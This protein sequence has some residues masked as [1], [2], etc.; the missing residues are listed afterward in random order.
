MTLPRVVTEVPTSGLAVPLPWISAMV[1][2]AGGVTGPGSTGGSTGAAAPLA[3]LGV[4]EA[5]SVKS[6]ELLLL[7]APLLR[8]RLLTSLLLVGAVAAWVSK[9]LE[10]P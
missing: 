3:A 9:V 2:V 6:A 7:S 1:L 8:F 10:V 4:I 5:F